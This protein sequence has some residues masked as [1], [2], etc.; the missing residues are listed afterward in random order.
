[1][2]TIALILHFKKVD[3]GVQ[4]PAA[5]LPPTKPSLDTKGKASPPTIIIQAEPTKPPPS[6]ATKFS[7][8]QPTKPPRTEKGEKQLIVAPTQALS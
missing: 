1:M 8:K 7:T 3:L 5:A 6:T 2:K 4:K